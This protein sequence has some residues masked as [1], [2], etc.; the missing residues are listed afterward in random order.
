MKLLS[1]KMTKSRNAW[2]TRQKKDIYVQAAKKD[3][4]RS[5]ASYKLIELQTKYKFLKPGMKVV[6]LG[7]APGGW[8]QVVID[9]IGPKG[10]LWA[11][12]ILAIDPITNVKV[13]QGDFTTQE[14][15]D[16]LISM[17]EGALL[18]WVVSDIAPNMSGCTAVDQ[19][20]SMDL[21]ENVWDFAKQH[22]KPQGGLLFKA[23]QGEGLDE[24]VKGI[25]QNF[26]SVVIKKP[27]SSRAQS[28]E[29]Y[30]LA[31]GYNI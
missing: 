17:L 31:R 11:L 2:L 28:R 5:R 13:I 6:D 8:S 30:V 21:L 24:F 15:H 23:F 29:V 12:D 10:S 3:G 1:A 14:V 26:K 20:K 4:Y 27:N 16:K 9:I 22:L 25:K 7:A 18:D 19:P